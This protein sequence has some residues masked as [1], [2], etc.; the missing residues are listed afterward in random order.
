[1]ATDVWFMDLERLKRSLPDPEATTDAFVS[2]GERFLAFIQSNDRGPNPWPEGSFP[3]QVAERHPEF[4]AMLASV[5]AGPPRRRNLVRER[6]RRQILPL[7]FLLEEKAQMTK[8]KRL[9]KIVERIAVTIQPEA[10]GRSWEQVCAVAGVDPRVSLFLDRERKEELEIQLNEGVDGATALSLLYD[11][12]MAN[13]ESPVFDIG[14]DQ[15]VS[16]AQAWKH[17]SEGYLACL[18]LLH[19]YRPLPRRLGTFRI[20]ADFLDGVMA[21]ATRCKWRILPP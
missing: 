9:A 3:R 15:R 16:A 8:N 6:A 14:V 13:V 10:P 2:F 20:P 11:E 12:V 18:R 5:V 17:W 7:Y 4:A 1:M 21:E 19:A